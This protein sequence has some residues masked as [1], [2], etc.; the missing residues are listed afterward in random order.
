MSPQ[1]REVFPTPVGVFQNVMLLTGAGQ[2]S[3][4]RPW[5]CFRVDVF[6]FA[7]RRVFPTPVGVFLV[8]RRPKL[9]RD[10]LP[11]ARG[12]VSSP[13]FPSPVPEGSSPRPW[14]CFFRLYVM[15]R[16]VEVFPTP[17]G[18]FLAGA[19]PR[20]P[21]IRLPHAREGVSILGPSLRRDMLSS[22]RPWGCFHL[23]DGVDPR[24]Q[25]FPTPVGVFP[26]WGI[27][28]I[29]MLSLPHA[30]GGVSSCLYLWGPS[31]ASSP[32]PWGCFHARIVI[33]EE[34]EVFPTLVGVFPPSRAS[35]RPTLGLPHAR[36]GVLTEGFAGLCY[37]GSS[38]RPW[39][40]F[41]LGS[42]RQRQTVGLPHARGGVSR[43]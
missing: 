13:H 38:P 5:G 19:R 22:P 9:S 10:S 11:H 42:Q 21:C 14:G 34:M 15:A 8:L 27:C 36:G 12:G 7:D 41:W 43:C 3:S 17:V 39:G 24:L 25:V 33:E 26:A 31:L 2:L 1:W 32:R 20:S 37:Q 29:P 23:V 28:S 6:V 35:I 40:C 30:R 16:V 18:V 4:P